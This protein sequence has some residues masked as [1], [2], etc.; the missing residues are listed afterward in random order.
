MKVLRAKVDWHTETEVIGEN[1]EINIDNRLRS[2]VK[3]RK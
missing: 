2:L 1:L 3:T